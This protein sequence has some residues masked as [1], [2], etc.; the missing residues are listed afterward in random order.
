MLAVAGAVRVR[1][2]DAGHDVAGTFANEAADVEL[3]HQRF[4]HRE[5]R[6]VQRDIDHLPTPAFAIGVAPLLVAQGHQGAD[7]SP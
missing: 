5:Y 6:F 1:R 3:G 4:H 2:G 7:H